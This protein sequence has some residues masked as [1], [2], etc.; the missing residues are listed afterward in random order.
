MIMKSTESTGVTVTG[1]PPYR[2]TKA[3]ASHGQRNDANRDHKTTIE[4]LH[5]F[6]VWISLIWP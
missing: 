4:W 3:P 2:T 5:R 6:S 1:R